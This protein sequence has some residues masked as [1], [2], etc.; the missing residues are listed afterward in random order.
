MKKF[1]SS[2]NVFE[3]LKKEKDDTVSVAIGK[4]GTQKSKIIEKTEKNSENKNFL[5]IPGGD[6]TDK[7]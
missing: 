6:T 2:N 7:K 3:I 1:K 5:K 4:K